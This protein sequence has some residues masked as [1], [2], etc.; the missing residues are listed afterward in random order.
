MTEADYHR[1][2]DA[3]N[4]RDYATLETFFADDFALENAG[5]RVQGKAAFREFYAF[6]HHYCREEV[7]FRG[8]YP[9]T[10]GF[11]ANVVIRFEAIEALSAEVLAEK[12]FSGIAPMAKGAV[13]DIEFLILYVLNAEGLIQ[14][15]KGA[16]WIPAAAPSA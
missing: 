9:G 15:I 1:Y 13:V 16:V 12:G 11:V 3:F 8:F 4:A 6:F 5:F 2:I 14:H 10:Q 7:T